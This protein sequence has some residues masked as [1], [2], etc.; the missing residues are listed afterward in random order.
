MAA[1]P[2]ERRYSPP[3]SGGEAFAR[4]IEAAALTPR[5]TALADWQAANAFDRMG[6]S[7]RSGTPTIILVGTLTC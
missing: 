4:S 1:L 5:A 7:T 2:V 6:R 3:G